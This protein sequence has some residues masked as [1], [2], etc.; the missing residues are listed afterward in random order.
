VEWQVS[1][2]GGTTWV[3]APLL[4]AP[5]FSGTPPAFLNGWEF[6]AVFTNGGGTATTKAVTLTLT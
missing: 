2:N 4:S 1:V 5:T 6:R 3:N